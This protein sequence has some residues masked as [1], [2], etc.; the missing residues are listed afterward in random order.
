MRTFFLA[1]AISAIVF[2]TGTARVAAH[3]YP[4][5]IEGE[6][7][8]GGSGDCSFTTFQQCQA[9]ASGRTAYCGANLAFSKVA[10]PV[11]VRLHHLH[12]LHHR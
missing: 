2:T 5:C 8:S 9:A 4:Y 12:H 6:E 3:D 11:R 1:L 7:F 10:L